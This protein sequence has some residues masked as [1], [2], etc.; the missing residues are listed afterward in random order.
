M[1]EKKVYIPTP[2]KELQ[3]NKNKVV[4]TKTVTTVTTTRPVGVATGAS[5]ATSRQNPQ[6]QQKPLS[7]TYQRPIQTTT[8]TT[9]TTTRP[10]NSPVRVPTQSATM[11][12]K[13]SAEEEELRRKRKEK[14]RKINII[15]NWVGFVI[16]L[17][18]MAA[19]LYLFFTL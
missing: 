9:V 8:T 15:V 1:E 14:R 4:T 11:Q 13:D 2:P 12:T 18:C 19:L 7:N 6:P 5:G 17:G 3:N 16:A 10:A